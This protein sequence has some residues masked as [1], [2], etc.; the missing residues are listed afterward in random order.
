MIIKN[1]NLS[2]I[3]QNTIS[4]RGIAAEAIQLAKFRITKIFV[5]HLFKILVMYLIIMIN[6][7]QTYHTKLI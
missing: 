6:A 3:L 5:L 1:E 4:L 7:N 2:N